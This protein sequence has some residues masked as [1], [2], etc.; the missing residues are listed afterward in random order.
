MIY[1]QSVNSLIVLLQ[2]CEN[3]IILWKAGTLDDRSWRVK[4]GKVSILH[5]F[6]YKECDIWYMRFSLDSQQKVGSLSVSFHFLFSSIS[7]FLLFCVIFLFVLPS[8]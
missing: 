4:E 2:S 8:I 1:V 5:R 6:E 3:C 7:C